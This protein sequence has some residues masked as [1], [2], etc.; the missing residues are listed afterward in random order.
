MARNLLK[1]IALPIA[2]SAAF[3]FAACGSDNPIEVENKA[4]AKFSWDYRV[5]LDSIAQ[6]LD[7]SDYYECSRQCRC[8]LPARRAAK[9]FVVFNR[10]DNFIERYFKDSGDSALSITTIIKM[11]RDSLSYNDKGAHI[12]KKDDPQIDYLLT[13]KMLNITLTSYRQTADSIGKSKKNADP[14]VR[15]L[16]RTYID[17]EPSEYEPLSALALDTNDIKEWKGEKAIAIQLPRGIDAMDICP[18]LRDKSVEDDYYDD[19]D[20]LDEKSCVTVKNLGWVKEDNVKT[21]KSSSDKAEI[22]WKW[23]LY[24]IP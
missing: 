23:H 6:K 21:E 7:E 12:G 15:F 22:Q 3:F 16:I 5:A 8:C 10:C 2:V 14:E 20:L 17:L 24:A 18:V 11:V 19:E 9:P 13:N 1:K 4:D